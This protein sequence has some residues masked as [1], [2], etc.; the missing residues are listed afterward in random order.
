[1]NE[2]YSDCQNSIRGKWGENYFLG[3]WVEGARCKNY[4]LDVQL[5][6][7]YKFKKSWNVK[8]HIN[9]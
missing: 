7:I 6:L 9:L 3:E 5:L 4:S 8:L 2:F 1:M